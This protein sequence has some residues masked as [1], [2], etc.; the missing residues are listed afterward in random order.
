MPTEAEPEAEPEATARP[1]AKPRYRP[2]EGPA[3][4]SAGYR[5]FFLLAGLWALLALPLSQALIQGRVDLP[6]AVAPLRWHFHEL[7]FGY[8]AAALAGFLLTAIPNWTGRLPL[9][10]RPLLGLVCLWSLGRLAMLTSGT[11][12]AGAAALLDLTFLAALVAVVAREI[13][14]GRNR[15]NLPV[16]ILL[17]LFLGANALF[18]AAS[19]EL[20]PDDGL[21]RRA[22]IAAIAMLI[23]LIGGRVTPSFTRNW[24]AKR[25]S[26]GLPAAFGGLDR[27]ALLATLAAL[28]LWVAA[29][30]STVCALAAALAA[31]LNLARLLRWQGHRV[32][33]EPLLWVLHL[34]YLWIALG[35]A[36]LAAAAAGW[37]IPDLAAIHALTAGAMATMTLGV[38]SRA[39]LG[40][41]GQTLRAGA[42]LTAAFVL[43]S[44]AAA[45]RVT[46]TLS[47][48]LYE[49]LIYLAAAAWV[50]AFSC[51]VAV[52]APKLVSTRPPE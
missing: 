4:L 15:R 44:L 30:G 6:V 38:M 24:L 39:V 3:W 14:A 21:D 12:G 18:H 29:P 41:G 37:G 27:A 5:P 11:I 8:I 48:A 42:G 36:L 28:L 49:P 47:G 35:L 45:A 13:I 40:H 22:A 50:A 2:Y 33:A 9:Q 7:M 20:L 23:A 25:D 16:L 10:G 17:A 34:G 32:L 51:F 43:V 52:C 26:P 46:A 19:A 31:A 1:A